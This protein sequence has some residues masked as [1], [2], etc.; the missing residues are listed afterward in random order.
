VRRREG[1]M[2]WFWLLVILASFACFIGLVGLCG[3]LR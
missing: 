1:S 2:D 3:R